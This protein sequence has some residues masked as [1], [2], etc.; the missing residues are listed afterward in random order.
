MKLQ[1]AAKRLGV[2]VPVLEA[3]MAEYDLTEKDLNDAIVGDLAQDFKAGQVA[4][5]QPAAI[6]TPQPTKNPA[7]KSAPAPAPT[8]APR[9]APASISDSRRRLQEAMI[10]AATISEESEAEILEMA[11]EGFREEIAPDKKKLAEEIKNQWV[12]DARQTMGEHTD[13]LSQYRE[14]SRISNLRLITVDAIDVLA[15]PAG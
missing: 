2:T 1:D 8:P 7:P 4:V 15:L 6:A 5:V 9:V 12:A 13:R 11:L 3:K 10:S 14:Q